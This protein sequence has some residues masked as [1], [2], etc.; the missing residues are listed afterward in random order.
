MYSIEDYG[1]MIADEVRTGAYARALRG[2][3][4]PDST[5]LD[6][7]AGTGIFSLLAC[8]YGAR[9]VYA[10][11]ASD[12]IEV[13]QRIVHANGFDGRIEF[14]QGASTAIAL[15][16]KADVIVSDMHGTLPLFRANIVSLI[17][18]RRRMLVDGGVLIPRRDSLWAAVV[19]APGEYEG[20]VSPWA[21]ENF[22]L[23][24]D[25]AR[26]AVTNCLKKATVK[27]DH[28][29]SD[30]Q[31]WGVL[32][33]ATI[34][35]PNHAATLSFAAARAGVAH[36]L[37]LWFDTV[38]ADGI[39]ISNAPGAPPLVYSS[40]FLPWSAPVPLQAGDRIEV[41]LRADFSGSDYTWS[42]DSKVSGGIPPLVKADFRQS[43]FWGAPLSATRLQRRGSH[44]RPSLG[45]DGQLAALVL[46]Q[47]NGATPLEEI[48]RMAMQ[49]FPQRFRSFDE[50]LA[51][52][53]DLS[54]LY[55]G[56]RWR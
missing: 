20:L 39:E 56:G 45:E 46:G 32:D 40:S 6:L 14:I 53:A 50:A 33:Y 4:K 55:G 44:Y 2:A 36:G 15:A 48:A 23:D 22:G 47:M 18:A 27:R 35:T 26:H 1:H 31:C 29:V 30:P 41:R 38:L 37:I 16:D 5:V 52:V 11:E 19:E 51:R 8:Q 43:T 54:D 34:E 24:M 28:L 7:G 49:K 42:W 10:V 12:A 13:A 21:K 25:A 17:D 3:V 9:K